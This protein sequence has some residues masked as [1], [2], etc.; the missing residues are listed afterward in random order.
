MFYRASW[1]PCAAG[2]NVTLRTLGFE[3]ILSCGQG[4]PLVY[5]LALLQEFVQSLHL[6][7]RFFICQMEED[8]LGEC[9]LV[10]KHFVLNIP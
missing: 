6:W 4:A 8:L 7:F 2:V 10:D 5:S 9:E 1:S 3:V